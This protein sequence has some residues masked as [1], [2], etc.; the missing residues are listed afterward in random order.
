[1]ITITSRMA[2]HQPSVK[3]QPRAAVNYRSAR[4]NAV[5]AAMPRLLDSFL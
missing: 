1:M 3:G 4:R 2:P 5:R